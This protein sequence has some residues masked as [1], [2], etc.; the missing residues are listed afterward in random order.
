MRTEAITP[1]QTV[2]DEAVKLASGHYEERRF[3]EAEAVLR[4]VLD[5]STDHAGVFYWLGASLASQQRLKEALAA[6]RRA[7]VLA[8]LHAHYVFGLGTYARALFQF[9]E[10]REHFERAIAL[11]PDIAAYQEA[12]ASLPGRE[13]PPESPRLL[14]VGHARS[15]T[16][17]LLTALNTADR[18][19]L[20][21]EAH[22][23]R[24]R[25]RP[26]FRD[27]FNL[28]HERVGNQS[29]KS[30]YAP[31]VAGVPLHATGEAYLDG[32]ANGMLA[33]GEKVVLGPTTQGHDFALLRDYLER[34][35]FWTTVWVLRQPRSI[36]SSCLRRWGGD[37]TDWIMSVAQTLLLFVHIARQLPQ[38]L[39]V[40]HEKI[41][42]ERLAVLG[43]A[44]GLD[45]R[46]AADVYTPDRVVDDSFGRGEPFDDDLM[47]LE[48][49]HEAIVD[50]IDVETARL[51][52]ASIQIEQH[53]PGFE[54]PQ[55]N[56]FGRAVVELMSL[57]GNDGPSGMPALP[58]KRDGKAKS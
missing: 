19:H 27:R 6:G 32:L 1:R 57:V 5:E 38:T 36:I 25:G 34:R 15:G 17:V 29:T 11:A 21:G 41:G 18:V 43:S 53:L 52:P 16:T 28:M 7:V 3:V 45:L 48:L 49:A 33:V 46:H 50:E 23:Y 55:P 58:S 24:D 37:A 12:L 39:V 40:E 51:N 13:T 56:A 4:Q 20:L 31:V 8:P 14:V 22:L 44:L 54:G 42:R 9:D 47:R 2:S 35:R 10:A 26:Y 30:A